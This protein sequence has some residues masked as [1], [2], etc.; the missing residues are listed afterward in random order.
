MQAFAEFTTAAC[1][2]QALKKRGHY[3]KKRYIKILQVS[4]QEMQEQVLLGT[5]AIPSLRPQNRR[6]NS[7]RLS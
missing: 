1:A 5:A 3:L 6:L 7:T 2:V 4:Y